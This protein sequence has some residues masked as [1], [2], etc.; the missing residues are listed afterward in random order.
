LDLETL[1]YKKI[2][3]LENGTMY[4]YGSDNEYFAEFHMAKVPNFDGTDF[5]EVPHLKLQ[6]PGNTKTVYDQP[7]R[8]ET[9]PDRPSDPERFP[10]AWAAFQAGQTMGDSGTSIYDWQGCTPGDARRFEL[11][12][13]KTVEQLAHVSDANLSGLG[14]GALALRE[15]ARTFISGNG[16]EEQL[17]GQL[18]IQEDQIAKLTDIVNSLL[19]EKTSPKKK[20][21]SDG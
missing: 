15:R 14:L 19:E 10:Q 3:K 5:T 13:I 8:F 2:G 7:V 11:N 6:A 4:T 16:V 18:A 1:D 9:L 12:G 17:R 20:D 21:K